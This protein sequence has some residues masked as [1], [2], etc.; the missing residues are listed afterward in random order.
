MEVCHRLGVGRGGGRKLKTLLQ[1][2]GW[3]HVGESPTREPQAGPREP[4]CFL[5]GA[6]GALAPGAVGGG[7]QASQVEGRV[8][9]SLRA[10]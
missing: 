4:L 8:W 7:A 5:S 2:M 1:T 3:G 10:Q 9:G 6:G